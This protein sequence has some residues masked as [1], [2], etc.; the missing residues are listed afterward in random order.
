MIIWERLKNKNKP[1]ILKHSMMLLLFLFTLDNTGVD[2]LALNIKL[3]LSCLLLQLCCCC[4]CYYYY[5]LYYYRC[6]S[7]GWL[8]ADLYGVSC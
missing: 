6:Y 4:C 5:Y 2:D 8:I 3:L 1:E 7:L